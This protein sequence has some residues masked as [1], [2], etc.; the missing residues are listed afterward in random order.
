MRLTW[1]PPGSCLPSWAPGWPHEPCYQAKLSL[2]WTS[3]TLLCM[4]LHK[5]NVGLARIGKVPQTFKFQI[6]IHIMIVHKENCYISRNHIM[7]NSRKMLGWIIGIDTK[8]EVIVVSPTTWEAH[9]SPRAKPEG[10]GE[11]PRSL[12]TPQW[13]KSRYQFLFYHDET[14]LMKNKQI[15]SI[16]MLKFVQKLSLVTAWL[17]VHIL[18]SCDLI[19]SPW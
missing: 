16:Q 4:W 7:N 12:V 9:H 5:F 18:G 11:L 13:P 1:G 6:Q 8:I 3:H 19:V 15:L 10:C 17:H 14:K 2:G